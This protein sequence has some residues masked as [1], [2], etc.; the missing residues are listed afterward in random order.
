M[1]PQ[2][3]SIAELP[4]SPSGRR[5]EDDSWNPSRGSNSNSQRAKG[6]IAAS[7]TGTT[8]VNMAGELEHNSVTSNNSIDSSGRT[9]SSG[10]ESDNGRAATNDLCRSILET[11][12]TMLTT[13]NDDD[14]VVGTYEDYDD[15][16]ESVATT[17]FEAPKLSAAAKEREELARLGETQWIQVLR[18]VT[19]LV[20]MLTAGLLAWAVY[21]FGR[22]SQQSSFSNEYEAHAN[23]VMESFHAGVGRQLAAFDA[24]SAS[25][26]G[27]ALT[28]GATFPNVTLPHWGILANH[29]QIQAQATWVQF[30]PLVSN[31]EDRTHWQKYSSLHRDWLMPAFF[32][33]HLLRMAQDLKFGF[34]VNTLEESSA[35]QQPSLDFSHLPHG[36]GFSPY[37]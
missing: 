27:Y 6:A 36:N 20:L 34:V 10:D 4:R 33:M 30:M 11:K 29:F 9:R 37:I 3:K 16:S 17:A 15:F 14:D 12:S 32:Q 24:L 35:E 8:T 25:I 18:V 31:E 22:N 21:A 2:G 28:T 13:T 19:L 26:T 23:Q 7:R 1:P 5:D